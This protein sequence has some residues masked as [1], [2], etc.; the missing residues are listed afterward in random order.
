MCCGRASRSSRTSWQCTAW[1]SPSCARLRPLPC[2]PRH[3]R[4]LCQRAALWLATSEPLLCHMLA[5]ALV[6]SRAVCECTCTEH[7]VL[8]G[9]RL[10]PPPCLSRHPHELCQRTALW[11]ATSGPLS[12][13]VALAD[14]SPKSPKQGHAALQHCESRALPGKTCR[15]ARGPQGCQMG[16][17][18]FKALPC[19]LPTTTKA[20][21]MQGL[22]QSCCL[23]ACLPQ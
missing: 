10:C 21:W 19:L 9:A 12:C 7:A 13:F 1:A 11:L 6:S 8:D 23:P 4:E 15:A 17:A 5:L 14:I 20:C 18:I 2:L 22:Y 3:P 16:A